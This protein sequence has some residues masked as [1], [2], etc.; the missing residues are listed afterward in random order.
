YKI[1]EIASMLGY[2]S[3]FS[4]SKAIKQKFGSSPKNIT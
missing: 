3:P 1:S 2:S 4:F